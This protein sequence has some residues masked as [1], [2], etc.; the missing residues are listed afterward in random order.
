[1]FSTLRNMVVSFNCWCWGSL[2][3]PSTHFCIDLDFVHLGTKVQ[4]KSKLEPCHTSS[5]AVDQISQDFSPGYR[6][7]H[8]YSLLWWLWTLLDFVSFDR[9]QTNFDLILIDRL[10]VCIN[11]CK[12]WQRPSACGSGEMFIKPRLLSLQL[13]AHLQ[14]WVY[15]LPPSS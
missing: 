10:S 8:Y 12:G 14:C 9:K 5:P 13:S 11:Y 15:S 2:Q 7:A 1:M 6:K 4:Y 3:T